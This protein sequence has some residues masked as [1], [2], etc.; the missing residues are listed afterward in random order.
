M[1]EWRDVPGYEGLYQVSNL[2]SVKSL[3]YNHTG[4]EKLLT[5]GVSATGYK[6]TCLF[7][8]GKRKWYR[9]H[10][11]V[12]EAFNGPIPEGYDCN[13]INEIKTDCRLENLNLMT[14]KENINWGTGIE[15]RAKS[16]S[17]WVIKLSQN[18]EILHFYRSAMDASNET[19]I[20]NS[21]IGKCCNGKLKTAGGYIWKYAE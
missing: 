21:S 16:H 14:R 15:R 10:R 7:K 2:G 18:N 19:G 5:Q 13:H 9:T 6:N 20:D 8:N 11:L 1:E 17:K 12:W 3:N 4:E